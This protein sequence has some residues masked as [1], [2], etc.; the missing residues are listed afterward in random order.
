VEALRQDGHDIVKSKTA[1]QYVLDAVKQ[2]GNLDTA[3]AKVHL[4]IDDASL[5]AAISDARAHAKRLGLRKN[6][7]QTY[8]VSIGSEPEYFMEWDKPMSEQSEYIQDRMRQALRTHGVSGDNA[9]FHATGS[10]TAGELYDEL[11]KSPVVPGG[12]PMREDHIRR[13]SGD[14]GREYT[15]QLLWGHGIEGAKMQDYLAA[16][17]DSI[18]FSGPKNY[19]R[20]AIDLVRAAMS[21]VYTR[22]RSVEPEVAIRMAREYQ[23]ENISGLKG[24][25]ATERELQRADNVLRMLERAKP[26]WFTFADQPTQYRVY[27]PGLIKLLQAAGLLAPAGAGVYEATRGWG[28]Q[29]QQ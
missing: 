20:D 9:E 21:G 28:G 11:A 1:S 22:G 17:R 4:P 27:D 7:G 24:A 25:G 3:E 19:S 23:I 16:Q 29:P 6:L 10:R 26:E 15:S 12:P 2:F 14:V 13:Y 8:K 18:P 5:D